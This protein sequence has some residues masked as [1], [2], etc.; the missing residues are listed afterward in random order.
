MT[1][2]KASPDTPHIVIDEAGRMTAPSAERNIDAILAELM[3]RAPSAGSAI[4]IASGTGQ[5]IAR[6]AATLHGLLWQPSDIDPAR[7]RSITAWN[8]DT[9]NIAAPLALDISTA[10]WSDKLAPMDLIITVNLLHLISQTAAETCLTEA[11][12][13]L[14]PGGLLAIY[15]PFLRDGQATSDGDARFHA[16]LQAADPATGYKDV[17]WVTDRLTRSGLASC[18]VCQMPANNLMIFARRG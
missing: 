5:Q 6:F 3:P 9:P 4:E 15:G 18:E 10:G 16:S 7:L 8:A 11:A 13:S 12:R 2:M 1:G 14:A 17:A